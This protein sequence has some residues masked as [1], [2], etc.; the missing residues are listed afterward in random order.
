MVNI[1]TSSN[2][3]HEE[4][5]ATI[6]NE[7]KCYFEKQKEPLVTNKS[8]EDLFSKLKDDLFK[9]FDEKISDQNVKIEK[10]ESILSI[11][12]NII[13]LLLVK[14]DD[15]EQYI[16]R[17]CLRIHGVEFK[18]KESEDDVVINTLEKFSSSL[19]VPFDQ[20]D[21]DRAHHIGLSYTDNHSGKKVKSVIVKFRSW[22]AR[23]LF[24]KNP[25]RYH[26]DGLNKPGFSDSVDLT[27]RRDLSLIKAKGLIEGNTNKNYVCSDISC[28]PA[29]R[30]KDN[31]F[32]YFN[33][34]KELHHLLND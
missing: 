5:M 8:L 30:F 4:I 14:C 29:L 10:L 23:K 9:K 16:R 31:S 25:P 3:K 15:N 19:N 7:V 32:K 27:K 18:E 20:N 6:S 21:I 28:S 26:T 12:E 24:F 34:E 1:R 17:S 33:S 11:H 2:N 13:D 22:K